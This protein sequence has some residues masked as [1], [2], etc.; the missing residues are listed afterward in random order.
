MNALRNTAGPSRFAELLAAL[1]TGRQV[2]PRVN[3]RGLAFAVGVIAVLELLTA[4][5]LVSVYVP[6]PSEVGTSLWTLIRDGSLTSAT[7]ATLQTF[8]LGLAIATVGG[9]VIGGL[10]GTFPT[11]YRACRLIIEFLRPLPS[12]ALIPFIILRF[13]VGQSAGVIMA[14]Y[15]AFWPILFNTC[16]AIRDVNPVSLDVARV[17]GVGRIATIWRVRLPSAASG[18]AAGIRISSAIALILAITVEMITSSGGLGYFI[19][20]MQTAIRPADMYAGI[21]AVGIIGWLV[22]LLARVIERRAI[23]WRTDAEVSS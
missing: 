14:S 9:V 6:R 20:R 17:F 11:L 8:A 13:G 19:M 5:V 1:G 3:L 22:N 16:F 15:A 7:G 10:L 18:I 23:Y 12:V 21:V 4:T 2:R